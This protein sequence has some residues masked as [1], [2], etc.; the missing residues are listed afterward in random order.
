MKKMPIQDLKAWVHDLDMVVIMLEDPWKK[1]FVGLICSINKMSD[2]FA[3]MLVGKGFVM[4]NM[5]DKTLHNVIIKWN[6]FIECLKIEQ[7]ELQKKS[8]KAK[9]S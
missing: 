7:D 3:L 5:K 1:Q 6:E 9:H 8:Q 4:K 2:E